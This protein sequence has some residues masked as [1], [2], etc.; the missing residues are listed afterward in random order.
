MLEATDRRD[1]ATAEAAPAPA[2]V[3]HAPA[4]LRKLADGT[5]RVEV[6]GAPGVPRA[7][8]VHFSLVAAL[9]SG[10]RHVHAWRPVS[11]AERRAGASGCGDRRE[12]R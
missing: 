9:N 2:A 5:Y 11:E 3:T 6:D 10:A 8:A 4:L 7:A 12:R 1:P